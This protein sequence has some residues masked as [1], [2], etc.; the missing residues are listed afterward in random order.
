MIVPL[1]FE[2]HHRDHLDPIMALLPEGHAPRV[3]KAA[4]GDIG[5]VPS[6]GALIRARRM[7]YTRIVLAQHGAGQSYAGETRTAR[8]PGYPGGKDNADVGLFLVPN[9][10]SAH[11]WRSA[12]PKTPVAVV[13][14]PKLETL[15]RK[16]DARNLTGEVEPRLVDPQA[17]HPAP[18]TT[19]LA[20]SN[21]IIAVSFHWA[22]HFSPESG[23]AFQ[24][25][26]P[27][28][29][30]LQKL[31]YTVIG[32]GHPLRTDLPGWYQR[33]GIEYVKTFDEVCRRADVYVCDNSST[34]FEFAST[35][36]P[37][38]L[39]NSPQ[40]RKRISH[41]LRF[42]EAAD[43]GVQVDSV[44][45]VPAAIERA[46]SEDWTARREAALD[47]VYAYRSG[48]ARRAADAILNFAG[49]LAA[50]A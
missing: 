24:H 19:R 7:G 35:G 22:A 29:L 6:Y 2:P 44:D 15:P 23:S 38:V 13:G 26:W 45:D 43:V 11:R 9:E 14:C 48:A 33:H 8:Q 25:F 27:G 1:A 12:Y 10:S 36:R 50:V 46:L 28:V 4:P 37:V 21:P 20:P 18:G 16:R 41:G 17:P 39:L 47:K 32:H 31:G 34:I 42:W 30:R 49:R 40:Y 5:L 3:G